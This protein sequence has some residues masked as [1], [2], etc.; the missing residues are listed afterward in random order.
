MALAVIASR[1]LDGLAAPEVTVYVLSS[2]AT[3]PTRRVAAR[4]G[5]CGFFDKATE[6][7]RVRE[8]VAT[9]TAHATERRTA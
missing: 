5:A 3:E 8:A 2:F 1:S 9:R 7:E 4:L 6:F